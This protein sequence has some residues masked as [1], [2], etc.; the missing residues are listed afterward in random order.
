MSVGVSVSV[1]V[2]VCLCSIDH[3]YG[4]RS[5]INS[6][7]SSR[8][9]VVLSGVFF[10]LNWVVRFIRNQP[11]RKA[12]CTN[13]ALGYHLRWSQQD[14][15]SCAVLL[16]TNKQIPKLNTPGCRAR[17]P[18][19]RCMVAAGSLPCGHRRLDPCPQCVLR[20]PGPSA[21]QPCW[22]SSALSSLPSGNAR[23]VVGGHTWWWC[24]LR[25]WEPGAT[26][27]CCSPSFR[28]QAGCEVGTHA[29]PGAGRACQPLS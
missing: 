9:T 24:V 2:S 20:G 27:G 1:R 22:P 12:D 14:Y 5:V 8:A 10:S 25:A 29:L 26:S 19:R 4:Q 15:Q 7:K 3:D 17:L 6:K 13:N 16:P 11:S 18:A 28:I 21:R 23:R